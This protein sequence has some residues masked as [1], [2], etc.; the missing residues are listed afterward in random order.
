MSTPRK[1]GWSFISKKYG[2]VSISP[3][4]H[5]KKHAAPSYLGGMNV[6]VAAKDYNISEQEAER[7]IEYYLARRKRYKEKFGIKPVGPGYTRNYPFFKVKIQLAETEYDLFEIKKEDDYWVV[8]CPPTTDF[9]DEVIQERLFLHLESCQYGA[10]DKYLNRRGKEIA[11]IMGTSIP[12]FR[13]THFNAMEGCLGTNDAHPAEKNEVVTS[14]NQD[15]GVNYVNTQICIDGNLI[16]YPTEYMDSV[17]IHELT[18]NFYFDHSKEFHQLCDR[19]CMELLG[20]TAEHIMER[21][22]DWLCAPFAEKPLYKIEQGPRVPLMDIVDGKY[23]P[24]KCSSGS[25]DKIVFNDYG[26]NK[27]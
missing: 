10:A 4:P 9:D 11:G 25:N 14:V 8:I 1:D 16:Y 18:H 12:L 22:Q 6:I 13:T 17:I 24:R 26:W 20:D 2:W 27:D 19:Y 21:Y 23:I 15:T 3:T 7:Q 5:A